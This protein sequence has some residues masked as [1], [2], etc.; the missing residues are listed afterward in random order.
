MNQTE[1]YSL[2]QWEAE[3]RVTREGVNGAMAAIDA[4]I[5]GVASTAAEAASI[6][7]N[8]ASAAAG[9]AQCASGSYTGDSMPSRTVNVGFRPKAVLI[10]GG[11]NTSDFVLLVPG[12]SAAEGSYISC[13]AT[14]F[15]VSGST[16]VGTRNVSYY[17][18]RWVAFG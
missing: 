2:P 13:S 10:Q 8:A 4:A 16:A 5:A 14:G 6:A 11:S 15:T 3:D 17:I 7:E 9:A 1:N 12:V 18:Y